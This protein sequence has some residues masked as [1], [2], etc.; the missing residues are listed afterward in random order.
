MAAFWTGAVTVV[1]E[2]CLMLVR[3]CAVLSCICLMLIIGVCGTGLL[4]EVTATV[5]VA[6]GPFG[7][8]TNLTGLDGVFH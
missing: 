8:V 4:G 7:T 3:V 6:T 1:F 5:C 2:G